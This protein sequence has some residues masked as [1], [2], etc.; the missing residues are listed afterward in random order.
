MGSERVPKWQ[1]GLIFRNGIGGRFGQERA[2][3]GIFWGAGARFS[4]RQRAAD[5]CELWDTVSLLWFIY[6][7][8]ETNGGGNIAEKSGNRL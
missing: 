3:L 7:E 8:C 6:A 2:G 1:V 4:E 5:E